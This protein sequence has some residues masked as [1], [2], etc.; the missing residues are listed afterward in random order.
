MAKEPDYTLTIIET[1]G[2]WIVCEGGERVSKP[3]ADKAKAEWWAQYHADF[4][5]P[6]CHVCNSGVTKPDD[7]WV[8]DPWNCTA[9]GSFYKHRTCM[10]ALIARWRQREEMDPQELE[11]LLRET[12]LTLAKIERVRN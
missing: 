11:E 6:F 4:H 2:R 9:E 8:R 5:Q 12:G 3:F 10:C 1:D 7:P